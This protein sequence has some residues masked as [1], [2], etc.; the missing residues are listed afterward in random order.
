MIGLDFDNTLVSYNALLHDVACEH[1]FVTPDCPR[2]K[3]AIRD[4][5]R[6]LEDG[7]RKWQALQGMIY[8]P[9]IAGAEFIAGAADFIA[10]CRGQ[11]LELC[12]VSLKTAH[13]TI[14]PT[15]TNLRDAAL[16]WMEA[17]GFFAEGGLGFAV[18]DVH[19][20]DDRTQK[21]RRIGVLGCT[22][23]IDDLEEVFEDPD[24]PSGVQR[25]LFAP[26]R[27]ALPVGPFRAYRNWKDITRA[28][29]DDFA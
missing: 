27:A 6:L 15:R 17:H 8:G 2:D 5:V 13:A 1:G 12:I 7:E 14:D 18:G 29:R 4:R 10:W 3:T 26:T 25:L 20:L 24:F 16:A 22:H 9:R 11:G 21:V 19:F 28:V 23:F